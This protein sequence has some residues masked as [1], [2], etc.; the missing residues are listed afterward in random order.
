MEN[1]I[2]KYN[3]QSVSLIVCDIAL[4][5]I[6]DNFIHLFKYFHITGLVIQS[7]QLLYEV[8]K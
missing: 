3:F 5:R 1:F 2:I 7:L 4:K 6:P 8:V